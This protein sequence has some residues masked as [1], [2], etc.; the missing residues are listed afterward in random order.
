[1]TSAFSMTEPINLVLDLVQRVGPHSLQAFVVHEAKEVVHASL[2]FAI[3]FWA[4]V[5]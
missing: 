4:I 2:N 1:M 5:D 3:Y